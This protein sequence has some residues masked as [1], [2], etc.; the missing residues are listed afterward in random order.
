MA[1]TLISRDEFITVTD[2]VARD[3][4]GM[5]V[6]TAERIVEEAV[7]FVATC[8]RFPGKGLRPS[9]AVDKGWHALILHTHT[10]ERLCARL[11]HFVHHT[12]DR[13]DSADTRTVALDRTLELMTQAGHEPDL[14]LWLQPS[15]AAECEGGPA[16][17]CD[18]CG[19]PKG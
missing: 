16:P 19:I 17:C 6:D 9:S 15:G 11:G 3:N 14:T 13:P 5:D 18:G 4:D 10:Y 12:P 8:A 1:F 2:T 7:K